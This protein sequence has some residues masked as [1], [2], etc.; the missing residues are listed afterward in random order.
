MP[1]VTISIGQQ[2]R[3]RGRLVEPELVDHDDITRRARGTV[4]HLAHIDDAIRVLG[5][6]PRSLRLGTC[7]DDH[8]MRLL[9]GD[10]AGPR[11]DAVL[12]RHAEPSAFG[13]LVA[14]HVA[15]L[16]AVRHR[17]GEPHLPARVALLL[18][19]RDLHIPASRRS[20]RRLQPARPR[21]NHHNPPM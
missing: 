11:A 10:Q 7:C 2:L 4:E 14:D 9:L 8:V 5:H 15:E 19:H 21:P 16:G 6:P 3:H 13:Q 17:C 18:V 12:D 20:D 1:F